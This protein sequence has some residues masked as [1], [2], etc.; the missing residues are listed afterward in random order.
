MHNMRR[1]III[2][3][4][5]SFFVVC[6]VSLSEN[7]VPIIDISG[8]FN[9]SSSERLNIAQQIGQACQDI[10]FFVIK[11]HNV[12]QTIIDD[13]WGSTQDFFDLDLEAKLP[14]DLDQHIYPFG[15]TKI[16]GEILSTGKLAEKA[17][18]GSSVVIS[19]TS[20]PDLKGQWSCYYA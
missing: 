15:Y 20:L 13:A 16:G 19:E 17:E 10:G 14:Y 1:I 7:I 2:Y 5:L 11:G 3:I 9:G 8:F 6:M 12:P 4:I 18:N